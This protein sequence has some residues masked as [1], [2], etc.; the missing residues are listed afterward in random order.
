MNVVND[1]RYELN[2]TIVIQ[3]TSGSGNIDIGTTNEITFTITDD[4][5]LAPPTISFSLATVTGDEGTTTTITISREESG[6][7][8]GLTGTVDWTISN[9]SSANAD[10]SSA[11]SGSVSFSQGSNNRTFNYTSV[12][13]AV[14]EDNETFT[15]TLSNYSNCA[16]GA[17]TTMTFSIEDDDDPPVVAFS[18]GAVTYAESQGTVTLVPTLSTASGRPTVERS[19]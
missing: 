1:D 6:S 4:E 5:A 9:G 15:V 16:A 2:E 18:S 19:C 11:T 17:I 14:D 8:F 7:E 13:D 12:N 10:H 3:L